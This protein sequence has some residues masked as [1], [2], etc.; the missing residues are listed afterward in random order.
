MFR[1]LSRT[2]RWLIALPFQVVG[3]LTL[4]GGAG[5]GLYDIWNTIQDEEAY[6]AVRTGELWHS[7]SPETLQLAQ[8]AIQRYVHPA[9]WDPVILNIL[10]LPAW[11][12]LLA[13][14]L[15]SLLLARLIYGRA[16]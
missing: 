9:L 6:T 1:A 13:T 12:V 3:V 15:L 14:A 4:L 5:V 7:L 2:I 11:F 16:H 10:L 8:P